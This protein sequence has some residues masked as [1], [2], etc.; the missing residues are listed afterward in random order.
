MLKFDG[1]NVAEFDFEN[2]V[3]FNC[4]L[5]LVQKIPP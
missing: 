4:D 5:K 3:N 1:R 2:G